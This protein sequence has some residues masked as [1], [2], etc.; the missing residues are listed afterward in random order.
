[1]KALKEFAP[2]DQVT[3][4]CLACIGASAQRQRLFRQIYAGKRP[5][6]Q[7]TD[8]AVELG[9]ERKQVL[10]LGESLSRADIVTK[11]RNPE[12]KLL[13]YGKQDDVKNVRDKVLRIC[14]Q[15]E[16]LLA[17]KRQASQTD[18]TYHQ[19]QIGRM[20]NSYNNYG[21][22]GAIGDGASVERNLNQQVVYTA[23]DAANLRKDF[24]RFHA[25]IQAHDETRDSGKALMAIETAQEH[26][27]EGNVEKSLSTF[28]KVV[29]WVGTVVK[30]WSASVA[31]E[32]LKRQM[33]L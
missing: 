14:Q 19:T 22:A 31:A 7:V 28:Q 30:E 29:P 5:V 24:E 32:L 12:T 8:L 27:A 16:R 26:L 1:M 17:A 33:G 10:E 4:R 21:Q 6:K 23:T 9:L 15:P 3:L 11:I 13:G 2:L 25:E 20:G 18:A